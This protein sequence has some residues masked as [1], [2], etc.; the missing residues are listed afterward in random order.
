MSYRYVDKY[1]QQGESFVQVS[2]RLPTPWFSRAVLSEVMPPPPPRTPTVV[3]SLSPPP[4]FSPSRSLPLSRTR[5]T[6]AAAKD[7]RLHA[8]LPPTHI[9]GSA[10]GLVEREVA[11]VL[12]AALER[13]RSRFP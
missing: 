2:M 5:G 11:R 3:P 9:D 8:P 4:L 12:G 10:D 6:G 13:C 1:N 7:N